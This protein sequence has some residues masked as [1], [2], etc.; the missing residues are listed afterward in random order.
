MLASNGCK[1]EQGEDGDGSYYVGSY[2]LLFCT[3]GCHAA[4][5][6]RNVGLCTM[7]RAVWSPASATYFATTWEPL[8]KIGC[9]Q[10]WQYNI[11]NMVAELVQP[12]ST[13]LIEQLM[14]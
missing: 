4:R 12:I 3:D 6:G 13:K 9:V 7:S 14:A 1:N 5:I 11:S 10:G 8:L 2:S